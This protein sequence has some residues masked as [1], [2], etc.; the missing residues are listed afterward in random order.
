[1][2]ESIAKESPRGRIVRR[3]LAALVA[4]AA[5]L[6]LG[7]CKATGGGQIDEPVPSG[8]LPAGDI[9]GTFTGDANFGFN[10]TCEMTDKNKAVI[11]GEITYHDTGTSKVEGLRVR[12]DQASRRCGPHVSSSRRPSARRRPRSSWMRPNSRAPTGPKTRVCCPHCP[13]D[14][15]FW[16]S[17]RVSLAG[18]PTLHSSPATGSPSSSPGAP[19][20]STPGPATSRAATSRWTTPRHIWAPPAAPRFEGGRGGK[21]VPATTA[22]M[23][24]QGDVWINDLL[25]I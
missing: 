23:V 21:I 6:T 5:V 1:M 20:P 25:R 7:A 9:E 11:K 17:T 19:T 4:V 16:C 8:V 13:A 3:V 14:L 18:R 2:Q 10:F 15:P 22:E 12:R 24:R